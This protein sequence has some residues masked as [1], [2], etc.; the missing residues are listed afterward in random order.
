MTLILWGLDRPTVDELFNRS[1]VGAKK[2][3]KDG[4]S[5]DQFLPVS[6]R[7]LVSSAWMSRGV[8][9]APGNRTVGERLETIDWITVLHFPRH[10]MGVILAAFLTHS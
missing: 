10:E 6:Q 1:A 8:P 4:G 3:R 5:L 2:G 7:N 9:G